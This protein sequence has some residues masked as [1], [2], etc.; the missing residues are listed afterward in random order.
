MKIIKHKNVITKFNSTACKI[1]EYPFENE[2]FDLSIAQINGR[3][4]ENDYCLNKECDEIFLLT[5]GQVTLTKKGSQPETLTYGDSVFLNAGEAYFWNGNCRMV[6][7]CSPA[8]NADQY[9]IIK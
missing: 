6:V 4:P 9:K 1:T 3:Y 5:E 8:W 7:S 2:S